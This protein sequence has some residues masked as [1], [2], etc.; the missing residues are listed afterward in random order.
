MT[1][2][3]WQQRRGSAGKSGTAGGLMITS[4]I[5]VGHPARLFRYGDADEKAT[6]VQ[7]A[8]LCVLYDDLQLEFAAANEETM[9]PLDK[10]G[11]D[12]RR[13]Y[14][15][16][17]TLA[18]LMELRG[19]IAVLDQNA[20][21]QARKAAWPTGARDGWDKAAAF[22]TANHKFLKNWRND[23]GGHFLDESAEFAIDNIEDD[24]V[25]TI[26]LFRRGSGADVRIK[27]A[28][29]LV[30]VA[31]IKQRDATVHTPEEFLIEA[32]RFLVDARCVMP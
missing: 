5:K 26:E 6:K 25:G 29:S 13:F 2:A 4:R 19:A 22:F 32:F 16:R 1:S 14:F 27:F 12:N 31:L 20:T 17:R 9:P 7:F 23:V 10:S 28:F 3:M 18:T 21:F 11:R 8:R 24:A 30:A 15:V